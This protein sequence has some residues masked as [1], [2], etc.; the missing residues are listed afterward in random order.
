MVAFKLDA[1]EA[2]FSYWILVNL[3]MRTVSTLTLYLIIKHH[4]TVFYLH[5]AFNDFHKHSQQIV[6]P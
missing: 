4:W 6:S 5:N 1:A 3:E 2:Q